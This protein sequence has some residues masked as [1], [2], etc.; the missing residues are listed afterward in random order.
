MTS[1]LD[2]LTAYLF[3]VLQVFTRLLSFYKSLYF[4]GYFEVDI[5]SNIAQL[6]IFIWP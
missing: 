5:I 4:P 6:K 3:L 1:T 2:V